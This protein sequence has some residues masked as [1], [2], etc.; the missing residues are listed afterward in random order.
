[1]RTLTPAERRAFRATAHHLHP[2]VSIGQHGLTSSVLHEID[3]SLFAHQLI[4]IRVFSDGRDERDAMLARICAELDAAAVQ[5]LGKLLIVW[6][7]APAPD[8]NVQ[9]AK[10]RRKSAPARTPDRRKL[11]AGEA[12]SFGTQRT[13][14]GTV[15]KPAPRRRP[16]KGGTYAVPKPRF[17]KPPRSVTA[18]MLDG[19]SRP[20]RRPRDPAGKGARGDAPSGPKSFAP[21]DFGQGRAPAPHKRPPRGGGAGKGRIDS[22]SGNGA[23]AGARRRRTPR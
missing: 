7:P 23:A 21:R 14:R 2:V 18:A 6:R 11:A 9:P 19:D 3:I 15:A 20:R 13:P 1:M 12:K 8:D 22:T 16:P 17:G 4:K 10:L 5:H